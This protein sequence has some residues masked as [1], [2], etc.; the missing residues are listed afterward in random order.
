M[1][2]VGSSEMT[3]EARHDDEDKVRVDLIPSGIL[4]EVGRVFRYG[5]KKYGAN[6]WQRG[7]RWN[8]LYASSLRHLLSWQNGR[9][10][11]KESG[12]SHLSHAIANLMMLRMMQGMGLG[13]DDRQGWVKRLEEKNGG[14]K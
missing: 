5:A 4:V 3:E 14:E 7:M 1:P 10:D 6:N 9:D 2:I 11:D 12:L 13:E 8:R